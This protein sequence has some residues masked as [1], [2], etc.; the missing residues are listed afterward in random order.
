MLADWVRD[1]LLIFYMYC[2]FGWCFESTYVS[3]RTGHRVNRGFMKAPF[4]P[5]YGSGAIVLLVVGSVFEGNTVMIYIAGCIC[6][7]ILELVT[8]AGMEWLFQIKYW[9]YSRQRFQ[10]KGHICL[11]SAIAWG[12]MALLVNYVIHEPLEVLVRSLPEAVVMALVV[13][14]TAVLAWDFVQSFKA[15]ITLRGVLVALEETRTGTEALHGQL[16][17]MCGHASAQVQQAVEER[18]ARLETLD[19]E[20]AGIQANIQA[21]LTANYEVHISKQHRLTEESDPEVLTA[22]KEEYRQWRSR[23]YD[24]QHKWPQKLDISEAKGMR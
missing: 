23:F 9:D 11:S 15:A 20:L 19:K 13:V 22:I 4:L 2:F 5:L 21:E 24:R 3:I 18:L 8:G 12:F 1:W 7:T 6:A 10:Y 16:C 17:D 14:L